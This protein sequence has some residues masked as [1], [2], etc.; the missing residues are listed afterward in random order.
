MA[1]T[2]A[3]DTKVPVTKS[4]NDIHKMLTS[5]GADRIGIMFGG[6]EGSIVVF[7]AGDVMY[8][9]AQPP[10]AETIRNK[11]QAER[12]AWRA[13]VLLI[14]AKTVAIQQ[15]ISTIEREFMADTVMPDGSTLVEHHKALVSHN[16]GEDGPPR[17]SFMQ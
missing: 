17:L 10:L 2:Y 11:E 12:A 16:Y 3:E 14:K 6:D 1:R 13:L 4:H 9:F 15:G 7:Q 8:K 5:I